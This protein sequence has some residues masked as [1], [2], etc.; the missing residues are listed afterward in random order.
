MSAYDVTVVGSGPNGLAA[1]ILLA[2]AG[3][4]VLVLERNDVPGGGVRSAELTLPALVHDVCSAIYPLGLAS[5]L[6]RQLPLAQHGLEW[7]F[8]PAPLAHPMEAEPAV[9]LESSLEETAHGLDADADSYRRLMTPLVRGWDWLVQ[10]ILAPLRW[11]RHPLLLARFGYHALHPVRLLA[12]KKFNGRRARALFSGLAG[13]SFLPLEEKASAAFALVLGAAGHAVGWPIVKGGARNFTQALVSYLV[14][15][16]GTLSTGVQVK[17]WRDLPDCKAV[18]LDLT[19]RQFLSIAGDILPAAYQRSLRRYRYGPG[20][21]KIDYALSQPIPWRSPECFRA[22]TVHVGGTLEEIAASERSVWRGEHPD[23]PYVLVAQ[24]S[25]FDATRAPAGVHTCWAYCHVPS[26]STWDLSARIEKQIERFAPGFRDCI[27]ARHFKN[28]LQMENYNP[29]YVAGDINGGVQD[30][31]QMFRRPVSWRNPY[32]TPLKKYFLCS[33]STPPGGGVHG[34][35][36][37]HCAR[38]VLRKI[39]H[40]DSEL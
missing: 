29:N 12:E 24:Q 36:G 2:R 21:F 38:V 1:A 39:F 27:L 4:K 9:L 26:G 28:T 14:S 35:C 20:V 25:L 17:S 10:E 13:H 32:S 40:I 37:Y 3:L 7:I 19:P 15:L 23:R 16:G 6:F 18:L 8:P 34:M 31:S 11:P 30:L 5:P 22:G 33:S